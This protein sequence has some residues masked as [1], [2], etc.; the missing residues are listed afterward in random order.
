[1]QEA[2]PQERCFPFSL[3]SQAMHDPGGRV[4]E[5]RAS[6]KEGDKKRPSFR[7][8]EINPINTRYVAL[9]KSLYLSGLGFR[10]RKME[11]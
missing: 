4:G 9:D 11:R 3:I 10:V 8:W 1:M 7:Y 5:G 6:I 2:G